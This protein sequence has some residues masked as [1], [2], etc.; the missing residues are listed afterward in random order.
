MDT[1]LAGMSFSLLPSVKKR[2]VSFVSGMIRDN[3]NECST[4]HIA[5]DG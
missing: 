5:H 1:I 4:Q 3:K 2:M